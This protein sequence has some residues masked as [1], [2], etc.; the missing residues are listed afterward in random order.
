MRDA[1]ED[2]GARD[3]SRP[4]DTWAQRLA[5]EARILGEARMLRDDEQ[6]TDE[7]RQTILTRFRE[8]VE[9][10][11]KSQEWAARSMGISP[12][13]LSQVLSGNYAG[14]SE[15]YV[16]AIDKWTETQM[17]RATAPKPAGFVST[18][19]AKRIYNLAKWM[20]HTAGIGVVH[21]PA[22]CGKTKCLLALRADHP[23]SV[24]ISITTA[25]HTKVAVM[26][27]L[28]AEL[29][30]PGSHNTADLVFDQ[31]VQVLKDTNRLIL[32][33]EVH[34]LEGRRKDEALHTLRDLHDHTGCPMVWAGMSNIA[35]Y[36]Q[37]GKS[38][39]EPLDQLCS[40]IKQW[41]DLRDAVA[42]WDGHTGGLYT[43]ADIRSVIAKMQLRVTPDAERYLHMIANEPA[44]GHLRTICDSLLRYA[45]KVAKGQPITA[46]MIRQIRREQLG[47][48]AAAVFERQ[49]DMRAVAVAG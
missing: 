7:L 49:L 4:G 17:V 30:I 35:D 15:K 41:V 26:R 40:R 36:I 12:G 42:S 18:E 2:P 29:R 47:T 23:G 6:L 25:G 9:R 33:D 24:Y 22:G 1:S 32:V 8:H 31:L 16:R 43:I 37:L 10:A 45:A 28:A 19:V 48:K 3:G 20:I 13:T 21:G 5:N 46:D 27:A 39:W 38:R 14:D 11:G 34:K 44:A